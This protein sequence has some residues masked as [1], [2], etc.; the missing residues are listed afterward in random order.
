MTAEKLRYQRT[1][2]LP[3]KDKVRK[4]IWLLINRTI[5]RLIPPPIIKPRLKL[6]SLFGASIHP[7]ANVARSAVI[8]CPWNLKMGRDSSIGDGAWID[9]L[10]IVELEDNAIVGQKS[11]ILTGS[12]D[13]NSA[14]YSLVLRP[15]KIGYGVWITT[16]CIV[17]PG[18]SI[19]PLAV[20]GAGSV[21]VR[22]LPG[23]NVYAGNPAIK[24]KEREI[25]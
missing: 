20:V 15:V 11:V 16:R 4:Y 2:S 3:I 7:S 24:L 12:H 25:S 14:S 13:I 19:G 1:T 9:S 23:G 17:L 8:S 22:S 5:F 18:V 21:V 6:L 10:A